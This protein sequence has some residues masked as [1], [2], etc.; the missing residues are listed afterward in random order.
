MSAKLLYPDEVRALLARRYAA[1][2]RSWLVGGG[3]WPMSQSVGS[4]GE[5]VASEHPG[6]MRAWIEAWRAFDHATC[7][8]WEDVC[9]RRLGGQT[10]PTRLVLKDAAELAQVVGQGQRFSR[11]D[12]RYRMLVQHWPALAG[13]SAVARHFEMLADGSDDDFER[14]VSL[15]GWLVAHPASGFSLR[16]LP[17]PGLHTK[18][19]EK[20]RGLVSDLLQAIRA[21]D[22]SAD[23]YA[24]CGLRGPPTRLRMRVLCPALREAVGG[25]R[26]IESPL[27]ELAPLALRPRC[28]LIVE[29]LETGLALPDIAGCVAFMRLG[30]A[31]SLLAEVSWLAGA[32]II[33][34]GDLD[35]HGLAIL[36]RARDVLGDVQSALMNEATL[37]AHRSLWSEE[38]VQCSERELAQLTAD[39]RALWEGLHGQRWGT[40][41]RLEQERIPWDLALAALLRAITCEVEADCSTLPNGVGAPSEGTLLQVTDRYL[42]S[43]E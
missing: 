14:L 18:W 36:S 28:V 2:H 38:P 6:A 19:A 26:D 11:A 37:V 27:D 24:R 5:R 4:P 43:A 9:W 22:A 13:A 10:L 12:E 42:T 39:E 35:T 32:R 3:T 16:Q 15:L 34:W 7:L 33:Y 8:A 23:F 17:V 30:N 21:H 25:L 29:N 20:R 40:R 1:Q 31:V 41:V